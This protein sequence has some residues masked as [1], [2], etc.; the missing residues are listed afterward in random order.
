[1]IWPRVPIGKPSSGTTGEPCSQPPDGVAETMLPS[2]S[3]MSKCT[4]SPLIWPMRPT[5]GSPAPLAATA[6]REPSALRSWTTPP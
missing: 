3:T 1:M 6:A 5:V 2:L 4:V